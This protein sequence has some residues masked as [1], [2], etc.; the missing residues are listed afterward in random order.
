MLP[1]SASAY[2]R[3]VDGM[4]SSMS[5]A[6]SVG[7]RLT[8][9]CSASSTTRTSPHSIRLTSRSG[10]FTSY[11]PQCSSSG[12]IISIKTR[13]F[14]SRRRARRPPVLVIKPRPPQ[15]GEPLHYTTIIPRVC[16]G[17]RDRWM[18]SNRV[19]LSS[20]HM[21]DKSSLHGATYSCEPLLGG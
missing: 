18:Q 14:P 12:T 7:G 4:L 8:P 10:S 13:I 11:R 3:R 20:L 2:N 21:P 1:R 16:T 15:V 6:Q 19:A 5:T 17:Y 9:T